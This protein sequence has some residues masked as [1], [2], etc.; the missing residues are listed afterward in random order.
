MLVHELLNTLIMK[1]ICTLFMLS[2]LAV[3]GM[4]TEVPSMYCTDIEGYITES[5]QSVQFTLVGQHIPIDVTVSSSNPDYTVSPTLIHPTEGVV[6]EVITVT[7]NGLMTANTAIT[8]ACGPLSTSVSIPAYINTDKTNLMPLL[9][10]GV[11]LFVPTVANPE[12]YVATAINNEIHIQ[13]KESTA[14]SLQAVF[15]YPLFKS[16]QLEADKNYILSMN[17][18]SDVELTDVMVRF[19][20]EVSS[21][22]VTATISQLDAGETYELQVP[23]AN[24]QNYQFNV[25]D[26]V[27]GGNA[28]FD[29]TITAIRLAE[30]TEDIPSSIQQSEAV[31]FSVLPN[32]TQGVIT[33]S[34][35]QMMQGINVYNLLG[36]LVYAQ[37]LNTDCAQVDLSSLPNGVYVLAV[38]VAQ[39]GV[40]VEKIRKQ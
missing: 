32:P 21:A 4:A 15:T 35:T 18:L 34:S 28:P 33:V 3:V 26:F 23:I 36:K 39:R 17:L 16:L 10:T 30:D 7:Y 27:L 29:L 5:G 25:L 31:A 22:E 24:L 1:K 2:M 38:E 37:P 13:T 20:D 6:N 12:G 11:H 9:T 14:N 40:L 19:Y 8:V